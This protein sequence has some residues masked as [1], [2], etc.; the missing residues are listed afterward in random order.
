[1]TTLEFRYIFYITE[2]QKNSKWM[3]LFGGRYKRKLRKRYE[4]LKKQHQDNEIGDTEFSIYERM[5][6]KVI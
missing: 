6:L 1:M 2:L 3:F 4:L 5:I